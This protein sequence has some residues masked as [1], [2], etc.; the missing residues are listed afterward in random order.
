MFSQLFYWPTF[1]VVQPKLVKKNC[2]KQNHPKIRQRFCSA[3]KCTKIR[4]NLKEDLTM[5]G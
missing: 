1:N 4:Q 2:R 3:I 5:M